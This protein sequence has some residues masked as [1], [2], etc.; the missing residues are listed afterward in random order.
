MCVIALLMKRTFLILSFCLLC[1]CMAFGQEEVRFNKELKLNFPFQL[2]AGHFQPQSLAPV[3]ILETKK[4]HRHEFELSRFGFSRRGD[5][6]TDR[7]GRE[8]LVHRTDHGIWL[9]YQYSFSFMPEARFSPFL[10]GSIQAGWTYHSF[11]TDRLPSFRYHHHNSSNTAAVM[12]GFRWRINERVGI[13]YGLGINLLQ[14]DFR[15]TRIRSLA[16]GN[17]YYGTYSLQSEPFS[18]LR[19]RIGLYIK[20]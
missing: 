14:Y 10:A 17:Y 13:D 8:Y 1:I 20:L 6:E 19:S 2:A 11:A 12:P 16:L 18:A 4:Q 7:Q 15:L 9:R 5:W 3:L